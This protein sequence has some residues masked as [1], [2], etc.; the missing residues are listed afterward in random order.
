MLSDLM[1]KIKVPIKGMHCRSC[2]IIVEKKLSEMP[3][4]RRSEVNYK[5]GIAE[6]YFSSE[7]LNMEKV[8]KAIRES[9]YEI[10]ENKKQLFLSNNIHDYRDL[11]VAFVILL[12]IYFVFKYTN[13]NLSFGSG[14]GSSPSSLPIVLLIGLTAGVS[15]C[16]ALVGGLVLG[17]SARHAEKHPEATM[18]EKFRPHIFFNLGRVIGFGLLGGVL[19]LIGSAFQISDSVTGILIVAVGLV[20]ALLGLQLTGMFPKLNSFNITLPKGLSR[21]LGIKE[22]EKEYNHKNS[23]VLG[24]LTFFLPCGFTQAM[25]I[26]ALSTGSFARGALIMA[27]FALG[28]MPGLLGV[29]GITS[30]IKGVFAKRFFKFAGLVVIFLALFNISNGFRLLGWSLDST[31]PVIISEDPNV[32]MEDGVQVVSME[33]RS[34]GYFPNKFTIKKDIPVRWVIDAKDPYSCASALVSSKLGVRKN[35]QAG[36]NII[37]FTPKEIGKIKFSCSMGMY[38]G[39]FNVVDGK[40]A[41]SAVKDDEKENSSLCSLDDGCPTAYS[42]NKQ[43]VKTAYTVF[44]D[45]QPSRFTVK[46]GSPVRFEIFAKENGAGCMGAIMIPGLY[47]TPKP[48]EK[49]KTIVMEFTPKE[50][51]EYPITCAMG[52]ERGVLRVE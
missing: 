50:K 41:E 10:G 34:N 22:H 49:G 46:A 18:I 30:F 9:G 8:E 51:G 27:I 21:I 16:M 4:I 24:A 2:E 33:E 13:I 15:T 36:K 40:Q 12:G 23:L 52:M 44:D 32:V 6:V 47:E 7:K 39:Y 20:M 25:Q 43:I 1:N 28:T 45:I 29:G 14:S 11:F 37:E 38:S 17:I 35:L 48:L 3:E 26:Y 42:G 19:G 31:E 5:K